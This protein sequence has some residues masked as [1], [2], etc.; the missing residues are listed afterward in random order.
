MDTVPNHQRML[1]LARQL[2]VEKEREEALAHQKQEQK[3]QV[4]DFILTSTITVHH[5]TDRLGG[6]PQKGS[7]WRGPTG[8]VPPEG[9]HRR[10]P[11]GGVPV[12]GFPKE[13]SH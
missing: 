3:N 10:G 8:G 4:T 7:P 13:G 11:T 6:V 12:E 2:R 1:D 5:H 9:A